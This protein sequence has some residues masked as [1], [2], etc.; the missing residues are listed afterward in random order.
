MENCEHLELIRLEGKYLYFI[1]ETSTE[2]NILEHAKKCKN[3]R[4]Y[5]MD[6]VEDNQ[7]SEIF[8]NLFDTDVEE[9]LVPNYSEYKNNDSFID[10][11]IEWRLG[12]LEKILRDAELELEDLRKRIG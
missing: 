9:A 7:K 11:R 1:V 8:G 12:R 3:C 10:A 5:I 2:M 4:E 6:I